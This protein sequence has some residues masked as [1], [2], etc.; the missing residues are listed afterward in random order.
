MARCYQVIVGICQPL[1]QTLTA[2]VKERKMLEQPAISE[3]L[4]PQFYAHLA[5]Q[6]CEQRLDWMGNGPTF[7]CRVSTL[8]SCVGPEYLNSFITKFPALNQNYCTRPPPGCLE[9]KGPAEQ[10]LTLK[11]SHPRLRLWETSVIP[12]TFL[13]TLLA[14]YFLFYHHQ[15]WR[16]NSDSGSGG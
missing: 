7:Q 10:R 4:P 2:A 12:T 8:Q 1:Y 5:R 9:K 15:A 13:N 14:S 11:T 3:P 6:I 16:H